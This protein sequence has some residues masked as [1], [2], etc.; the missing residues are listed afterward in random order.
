MRVFDPLVVRQ[1]R[2]TR[3][4]YP[5]PPVARLSRF[6]ECVD[7]EQRRVIHRDIAY[8]SGRCLYSRRGVPKRR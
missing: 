7:C 8:F 2:L 4:V 6:M 1:K 3:G 5:A